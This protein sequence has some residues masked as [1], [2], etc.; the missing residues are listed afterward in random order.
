MKTFIIFLSGLLAACGTLSNTEYII[1][2]KG[3]SDGLQGVITGG[4]GYCK[5]SVKR[6]GEEPGL[7][8]NI[9]LNDVRLACGSVSDL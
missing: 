7:P 9:D 4:V 5:I 6:K 8:E 2:S 3:Q 1:V